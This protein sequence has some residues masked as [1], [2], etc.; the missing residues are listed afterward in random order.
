MLNS[1]GQLVDK[2][3]I[4]ESAKTLD[5]SLLPDGIYFLKLNTEFS[6]LTT[7]IVLNHSVK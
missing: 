6:S 4:G 7:K 2:F 3:T 1:F 5:L